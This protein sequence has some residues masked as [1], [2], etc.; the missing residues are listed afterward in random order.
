MEADEHLDVTLVVQVGND[1]GLAQCVGRGDGKMW[2][3]SR[4]YDGKDE[5]CGR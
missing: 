3:A 1:N 5:D 4:L 2:A